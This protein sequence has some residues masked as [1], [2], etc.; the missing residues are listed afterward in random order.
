MAKSKYE[1]YIVSKLKPM[2]LPPELTPDL[3][4]KFSSFAKR[5][6][7]IDET[8]VPGAFHVGCSWYLKPST[9]YPYGKQVI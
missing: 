7:W 6:L 1:K 5:A 3:I 4:A 2:E 9:S 8:L